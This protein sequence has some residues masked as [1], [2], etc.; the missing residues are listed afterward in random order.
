M[1][2]AF[3]P[4]ARKLVFLGEAGCGK[5]EIAVQLALELAAQGRAVHLFDL[6]Q[7]KPLMRARDAEALYESWRK[8]VQ[9]ETLYLED[10]ELVLTG[11]GIC[12]RIA[13]SAVKLLRAEGYKV[14]LFRPRTVSPFPYE[15]YAGLDFGR[16]KAIL[17]VEMSIPAQMISDVQLA[18]MDRCPIHT[19]LHAGGEI[20]GR[21]EVIS[22]ARALLAR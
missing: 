22:A 2:G 20:M 21:D 16:V 9:V 8:D 1:S 3:L 13:R 5:S 17:D 19:C 12:G 4:E 18:V 11:Y 14:G 6:D 7:T 10:A 15:T